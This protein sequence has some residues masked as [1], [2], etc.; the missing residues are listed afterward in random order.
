MAG[1]FISDLLAIFKSKVFNIILSIVTGIIYA[2]VLG[3]EGDGLLAGVLIYPTIFISFSTL[4]LRQ[5]AIYFI[6]N[7]TKPIKEIVSSIL[8]VWILTSILSVTACIFILKFVAGNSYSTLM[9]FLAVSGIPFMLYKDYMSGVLLGKN[10][11]KKFAS[12][13][14]LSGLFRLIGA[15]LFVWYFEMGVLGAL[16][17]PVFVG[18]TM[19]LILTKLVQKYSS[20]SFSFDKTIIKQMV[21]LGIVYSISLFIINL[22]YKADQMLLEYMSSPF[23]LGIYT[24]GVGLVEKIW[25]IPLLLGTIIFAGSANSKNSKNYSIKVA[26]LLR[27]SIIISFIALSILAIFSRQIIDILYGV[28]YENSAI[29]I[30]VLA[31]GI[32]FMVFFKVL[33]MDLAGR[34]KPWLA[35][36]AMGPSVVINIILNIILIPKFG[37]FGVAIA[38]TISYTIAAFIFLFVYSKNTGMSVKEILKY[39]SDDFSILLNKIKGL[40]RR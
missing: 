35:L 7:E 6:G 24:R 33:N 37:A 18:I 11:V 10:D 19:S 12:I 34:G 36:I 40:V 25:Q 28:K 9:I 17:A 31:P 4:G 21:G 32:L 38:S 26:K 8:T 20:F 3:P 23:E 5:S 1:K 29:I 27:I 15:I 30:Q 16:I 13:T 14:W 2:R 22:N 39:K